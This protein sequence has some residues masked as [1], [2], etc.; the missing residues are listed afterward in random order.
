[1][2]APDLVIRPL[3]DADY[4][5]L[6]ALFADAEVIA[7]TSQIPHRNAAFWRDLIG[8]SGEDGVELV[9]LAGGA[10]AGFLGV[11]MNRRPRRKHAAWFMIAVHADH[12]RRGIG[13]ALMR[14]LVDLA[15]NWLNLVKLELAVYADNAP[16]IALYE[17]FGFELEGRL[18]LDTFK[19]GRYVDTLRM[20]RFH[21]AQTPS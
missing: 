18:R 21:P 17:Q 14:E 2:N 11:V 4:D 1:M 12:Q 7:Q 20:A 3:K 6:E 9:A 16:A 13:K 10:L 15:D 5:G 8:K 19:N